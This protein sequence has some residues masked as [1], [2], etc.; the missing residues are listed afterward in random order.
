MDR[1]WP[2][3][4][5]TVGMAGLPPSKLGLSYRGERRNFN[6]SERSLSKSLRKPK[7]PDVSL[8]AF[9]AVNEIIP[10]PKADN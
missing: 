9:R 7:G 8:V 6:Q 1:E 4:K 5:K 3:D 10:P 2:I